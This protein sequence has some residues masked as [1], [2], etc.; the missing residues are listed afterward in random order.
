MLPWFAVSNTKMR[1]K[2]EKRN[3]DVHF[4]KSSVQ[5]NICFA[6]SR[7]SSF[8][9]DYYSLAGNG[10]IKDFAYDLLYEA[11]LSYTIRTR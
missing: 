5:L 3:T 2:T 6:D 10:F 8:F 7:F 9:N 4:Y 11:A 1:W